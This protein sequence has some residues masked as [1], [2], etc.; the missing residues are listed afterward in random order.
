MGK[1]DVGMNAVTGNCRDMSL[2]CMLSQNR[3]RSNKVLKSALCLHIR[4]NDD[5]DYYRNRPL[6]ISLRGGVISAEKW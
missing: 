4:I 2:D 1:K 6:P 3:H 5:T